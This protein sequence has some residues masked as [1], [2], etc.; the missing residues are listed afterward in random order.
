LIYFAI[1][2]AIVFVIAVIVAL[3]SDYSRG[4]ALL[5]ASGAGIVALITGIFAFTVTVDAGEVVVPVLFGEVQ[6]PLTSPGWQGIHP[7][8]TTVSMPTRTVQD[9]FEGAVTAENPLGAI[10]A[11]SG[12]GAT[13]TVDLT[14]LWHV[15]AVKA[16][17][18]YRTVG[19]SLR[20]TL[21]FPYIR[22]AT[23]NCMAQYEFEEARTSGRLGA[24]GCIKDAIASALDQR[25]I[26]VEEILLRGMTADAK[27]QA[28][29][30]QKLEA[31]NAVQEAEFLKQQAEVDAQRA[32]VT[33]E[34]E[35]QAAI[36]RAEGEAQANRLVAESLTSDILQL[37]IFET[38]GD[39]AV[40]YMTGDDLD[41]VIPLP[42]P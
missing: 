16:G 41:T 21:L 37:R 25:G 27:L 22:S 1:I 36:I 28:A 20:E 26:I 19:T 13:I 42:T 31:Q 39:K 6:A 18:L 24:A 11:L 40:V 35:R 4:E 7:F 38:L 32:V 17:D 33:A 2:A 8:A 5:V 34:G 29:I 30:D 3:V 12:E 14:A 23:R 10:T 9:T 15:D